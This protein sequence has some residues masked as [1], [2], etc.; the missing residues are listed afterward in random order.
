MAAK[1]DLNL[2]A[3]FPYL[4]NRVGVALATT[5]GKDPLGRHRLNIGMWRALAALSR[6]GGQRLVDLAGLT[7]IDVSTLSRMV[8]RLMHAGLVMRTRSKTSE[9]EVVVMLTQKGRRLLDRLIP[10]A[11]QF[12][13]ALTDG[14][15]P[16]DLAI[17]NRVLHRMHANMMQ[18]PPARRNGSNGPMPRARK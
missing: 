12:E 6:N 4:I 16:T 8:T 15:A 10:V 14:I 17:V 2:D 7:S 13:A 9:R 5:F 18:S 3:Y 11:R 1:A